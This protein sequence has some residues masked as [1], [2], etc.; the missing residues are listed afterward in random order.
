M[1]AKR[2]K[3]LLPLRGKPILAHAL[4]AFERTP[5]VDEI[6]LVAHPA[7]VMPCEEEIVHRHGL[8]K[9]RAVIAGGAS[10]HQSE[11]CALGT[12]RA[13]IEANEI[14][15]ILIHDGARPLVTPAEIAAVIAAARAT[16][17]AL[18]VG[19]FAK[20]ETILEVAED[21]TIRAL[22]PT[23]ELARAQTPQ[24]FAARLLLAAYDAA[25]ADGFEGTDT[26][27]SVE[28]LGHTVAAVAG[29]E[30]NLKITTPDDLRR[31]EAWLAETS[32]DEED[33]SAR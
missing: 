32:P 30:R 11:Q 5:E 3:I 12:L 9:V 26:A 24:A 27:A 23:A 33:Q 20:D 10:R 28:R 7:E 19:S 22:P 31:A 17:G 21:G 8:A 15:I 13:R 2:N 4:E 1:G 6:L 14:E 25:L 18:L 29:G 16:G